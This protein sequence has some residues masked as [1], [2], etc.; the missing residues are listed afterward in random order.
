MIILSAMIKNEIFFA[1]KLVIKTLKNIY[2]LVLFVYLS[3]KKIKAPINFL[4]TNLS[5]H[6]AISCSQITSYLFFR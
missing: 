3:I 4:S 2:T 1:I 5:T 6:N